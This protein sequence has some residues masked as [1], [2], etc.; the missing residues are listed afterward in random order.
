MPPLA[1]E[2]ATGA[3]AGARVLCGENDAAIELV[4]VPPGTFQMGA[5]ADDAEAIALER[6]VH[7][8]VLTRSF[9]LARSEITQAMYRA[10]TG[11]N[12]SQITGDEMRPVEGVSWLDAVSFANAV[13][14]AQGLSAAYDDASVLV[15][16]TDGYRLPT[17]AQWEYAARAGDTRPRYGPVDDIAWHRGNSSSKTH[18]VRTRLPNAWGLFDMLGNVRELTNDI[19]GSYTADELTDPEG[20]ATGAQRVMRGGSWQDDAA[21]Q[22]VSFRFGTATDKPL[23]SVGFRLARPMLNALTQ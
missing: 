17:E 23:S 21:F 14:A 20:P 7:T 12:P 22:R 3:E 8:V 6:P 16:G 13:S 1:C 9:L 5:A 10:V 18:S 11:T 15:P 4:V 19:Y 2:A